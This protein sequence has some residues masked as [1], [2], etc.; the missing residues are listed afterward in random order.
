LRQYVNYLLNAPVLT[1]YGSYRFDGPL[2]LTS[3]RAFAAAG[4]ESAVGHAGAARYLS[5]A[6][7]VAVPCRRRMVT[8]RPGDQALVLRLL[9][10]LP[11]GQLLSAPALAKRP[12]EFALLTRLA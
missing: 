2:T 7:G 11:E 3:A 8:L 5:E 9:T 6:L 1:A 12:H 4:F 10:R